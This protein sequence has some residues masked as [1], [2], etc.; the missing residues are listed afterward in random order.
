MTGASPTQTLTVDLT[1]RSQLRLV[2]DPNGVTHYDHADW[3]DARLTCGSGPPPPPPPPDTTPPTITGLTPA[4]G[5]TGIAASI[6]P[7]VTF[8]EPINPASLTGSSLGLVVTGPATPVAA[9]VTYDPATRT[10]TLDPTPTL[11]A[12]TAYTVTVRGGPAASATSPGWPSP[13]TA[14]GPSRPPRPH[15]H[16]RR[17][18]RRRPTSRTSPTASSPT[19][20]DRPRRTAATARR[21][22]AT[23]A[24]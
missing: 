5:A 2:I 8:S 23:A 14:A 11:A 13:P 15:H 21:P 17:P 7:T 9:T 6:S 22:P 3:A 10:A 1:G 16:R 12:S 19:T 20:G 24:R 18:A 4:D